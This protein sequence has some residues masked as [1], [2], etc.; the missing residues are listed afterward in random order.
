[1][2]GDVA[3]DKAK[4]ADSDAHCRPAGGTKEDIDVANAETIPVDLDPHRVEDEDEEDDDVNN[5][6]TIL[7]DSEAC[8]IVDDDVVDD[9]TVQVDLE[10]CRFV[11]AKITKISKYNNSSYQSCHTH[12]YNINN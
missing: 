4:S 1:M 6:E 8:R 5:D 11:E 12:S 9:E 7:V 2:N 3:D 10:A